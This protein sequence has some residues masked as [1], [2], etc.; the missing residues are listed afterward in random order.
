MTPNSHMNKEPKKITLPLDEFVE[1]L[2]EDRHY[3]EV[4]PTVAEL[5][6]LHCQNKT[7][8][9]IQLPGDKDVD[10][11]GRPIT[12]PIAWR[13]AKWQ[14]STE[15]WLKSKLRA[16]EERKQRFVEEANIN[17]IKRH[18]LKT[19]EL[20]EEFAMRLAVK[21]V[22]AKQEHKYLRLGGK[23]FIKSIDEI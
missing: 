11:L 17:R 3:R 20:N 6:F 12:K 23:P 13:F 1:I 10:I 19:T 5:L 7:L 14:S 2:L 8:V 15:A 16:E 9:Y 22:T 4:K 18:L 21:W